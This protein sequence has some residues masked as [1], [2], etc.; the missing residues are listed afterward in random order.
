MMGGENMGAV[1]E[2]TCSCV[3][4]ACESISNKLN[5]EGGGRREE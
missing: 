1:R 2:S 5:V 4:E 3:Q